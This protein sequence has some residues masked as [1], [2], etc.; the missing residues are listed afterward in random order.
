MENTANTPFVDFGDVLRYYRTR[1]GL[2]QEQLA[3]GICAR[4]YVGLLEK[5]KKIP[6]IYMI[7]A[8]S[9][10]MG[11]NLFDAYALIIEHNDF[12]T[13]KK[14]E[15]MD[16]AIKAKD[17][18]RLYELAKEYSTLPG[19]S[20]GIPR[21]CISHALSLYYS[22]ALADYEKSV[23]Y[24]TEGLAVS[25]VP[26]ADMAP[27]P[28]LSITDLCLL[29]VKS[30]NLC[31]TDRLEEGRKYFEYLRECTRLRF[32]QNRYIANRNRRFDINLFALTTYNICEFFPDDT[33]S[34]LKLLEE[35]IR[36]LN[37]YDCSSMQPE[38]LLYRA[39]YLYDTGNTDRAYDSFNA[40]YYLMACQDSRE[41]ADESA[42]EI[43]G[44]R[45]A[46]LNP[47]AYRTE[48]LKEA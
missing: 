13:H 7:S 6:T 25:G 23:E 35:S 47:Q 18:D 10:K 31:R 36:I 12:D 43:L 22:N 9:S 21:Q 24:A 38:L 41:E 26:G 33:E 4:E 27:T 45:L 39:R 44:E 29:L 17:I 15:A 46:R 3:E 20:D 28:V 30:V 8:F 34:N 1:N 40:G 32:T 16:E 42:R 19:F 48:Y 2:S 14:I 37:D 5:N 11:V